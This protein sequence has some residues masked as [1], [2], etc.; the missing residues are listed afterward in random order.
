MKREVRRSLHYQC[1]QEEIAVLRISAGILGAAL[2][3]STIWAQTITQQ[4]LIGTWLFKAYAEIDSPEER[5]P[6][7][8]VFEFKPDGTF[9]SRRSTGEEAEATY[10]VDRNT[11]I[12]SDARGDQIWAIQ[13][14]EPGESLVV[15][16]QGT[17]MFLERT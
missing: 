16:N 11:I 1:Q 12:Y 8:A 9:K 7:D 14:L 15:D 17:L 5:Q 3:A 6:V 13:S 2:L 4:Q 10:T